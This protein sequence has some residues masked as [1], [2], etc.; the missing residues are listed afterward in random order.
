LA[1]ALKKEREL[2]E[3]ARVA[4]DRLENARLLTDQERIARA[5]AE[6]K[7]NEKAFEQRDAPV[8]EQQRTINRKQQAKVGTTPHAASGKEPEAK[9]SVE[10]LKAR[11]AIKQ[12]DEERKALLNFEVEDLDAEPQPKKRATQRQRRP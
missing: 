6:Q 8:R 9:A 7:A 2:I 10:E 1:G 4:V 11:K 12:I 3:R 5:Y